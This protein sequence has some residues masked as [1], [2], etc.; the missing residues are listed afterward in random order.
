MTFAK[1]LQYQI[2]NYFSTFWYKEAE[3]FYVSKN[4]IFNKYFIPF[5]N[6]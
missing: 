6:K 5:R 3:N 4:Q 2:K 1:I